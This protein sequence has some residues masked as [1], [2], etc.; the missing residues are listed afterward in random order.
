MPPKA[1]IQ[2]S[3]LEQIL[4]PEKPKRKKNKKNDNKISLIPPELRNKKHS[5]YKFA[6]FL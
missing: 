2:K 6:N 4:K 5:A 3:F 1:K